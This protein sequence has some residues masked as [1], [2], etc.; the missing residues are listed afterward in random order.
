MLVWA[1]FDPI[2]DD[3]PRGSGCCCGGGGTR[4]RGLSMDEYKLTLLAETL[5]WCLECL[6][7][8]EEMRREPMYERG[9]DLMD[10]LT[11]TLCGY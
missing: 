3:I 4:K 11:D 5:G 8:N 6:G 2:T 10:E 1:R 9:C 7:E